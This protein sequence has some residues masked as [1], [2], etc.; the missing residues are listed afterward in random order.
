MC[1]SKTPF[2]T[3]RPRFETSL[4]LPEKESP[5]RSMQPKGLLLRKG[6]LPECP[7]QKEQPLKPQQPEG[8]RRE[9]RF[10]T[11]KPPYLQELAWFQTRNPYP[12]WRKPKFQY[13]VRKLLNYLSPSGKRPGSP[14][15][16][17]FPKGCRWLP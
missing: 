14:L 3:R 10:R 5:Y 4:T 17:K 11:W 9:N 6:F 8:F 1:H 2:Q 13:R 7:T 12:A 15:H 16:P